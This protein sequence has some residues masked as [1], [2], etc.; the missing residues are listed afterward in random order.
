MLI[1]KNYFYEE[2]KYNYSIA[3]GNF[4]GIHKGHRF[5][6]KELSKLKKIDTDRTA[7]LSFIP[8]PVK[9]LAPNKWK[10]NLIKFRTK[11]YQLKSFKVDAL[12]LI[13][14]NKSFSDLPAK[15]FIEEILLKEINVKNIIVGQ[16]FKFGNNREGDIQLL[17]KYSKKS[18]F[19]LLCFEKKKQKI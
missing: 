6:L 9:V 5:L 3:I 17:E 11:Y 10:K 15:N 1:K 2:N 16:D 12:F 14:F 18:K 8:H 19:R 13:T 4:D 7:V